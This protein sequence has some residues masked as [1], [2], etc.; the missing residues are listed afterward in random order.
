MQ[1]SKK[2]VKTDAM[3]MGEVPLCVRILRKSGSL[4]EL[5]VGAKGAVFPASMECIVLQ[6][7]IETG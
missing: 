4:V 5:T 1:D 7:S 2:A 3:E 6:K